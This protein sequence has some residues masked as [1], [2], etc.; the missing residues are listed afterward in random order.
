M[1]DD[2]VI[3]EGPKR[4]VDVVVALDEFNLKKKTALESF[5]IE[6]RFKARAVRKASVNHRPSFLNFLSARNS[7][8]K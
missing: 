8:I 1:T 3:A 6:L 7:N 5:D 4:V 2:D